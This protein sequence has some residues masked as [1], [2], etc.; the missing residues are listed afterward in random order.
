[1][2]L[3]AF[4]VHDL[5]VQAF[6]PPFYSRHLGEAI[7]AFTTACMD[8]SHQFSKHRS[9]YV[10]YSCGSF[11]DTSGMFSPEEPRRILSALEA[12]AEGSAA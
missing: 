2:K 7:R 11:D 5:A 10:L 4:S 12:V 6:Q 3:F 9:D 8:D 1:M